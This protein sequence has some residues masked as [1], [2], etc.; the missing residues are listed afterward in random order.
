MALRNKLA[1]K[2][3]RQKSTSLLP[4]A[5]RWHRQHKNVY[6]VVFILLVAAGCVYWYSVSRAAVSEE[7]ARHRLQTIMSG[8]ARYIIPRA[9]EFYSGDTL[10]RT[11]EGAV[12][13]ASAVALAHASGLRGG[14]VDVDTN[15]ARN[16]GG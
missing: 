9:V 12:R 8:S 15:A 6:A 3:R 11:D 10:K 7:A 2:T 5:I 1:R 14:Y 4:R 16:P 13:G